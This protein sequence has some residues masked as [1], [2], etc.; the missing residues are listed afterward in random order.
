MIYPEEGIAVDAAH[1][2]KN[3]RTEIQGVDLRTGEYLFYQDL[4]NQTVNIGEFLAIV[5]AVKYI[6]SSGYK[7]RLIYSDSLTAISWFKEKKGNS[8]KRNKAL[9]KAEIYL[10][11]CHKEVD[12]IEIRHWNSKYL[13]ENAADFGNKGYKRKDKPDNQEDAVLS[14]ELF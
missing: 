11:A 13:G 8:Q 5:K 14:M 12:T 2:Q 7:P 6:L 10:M 3:K 9:Q 4:G 1:S